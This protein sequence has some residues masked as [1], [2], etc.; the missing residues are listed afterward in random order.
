MQTKGTPDLSEG[1]WRLILKKGGKKI[2]P[3]E[4]SKDIIC[5]LRQPLKGPGSPGCLECYQIGSHRK[6]AL[7]CSPLQDV[8]LLGCLVFLGAT[9]SNALYKGPRHRS[10]AH[11]DPLPSV[12]Q[13]H[14]L[15]FSFSRA[16]VHK[17]YRL[18][19]SF[20]QQMMYKKAHFL[21]LHWDKCR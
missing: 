11:S 4:L 12:S 18:S 16:G 8:H 6:P 1:Q 5:F 21:P 13:S 7:L 20:H 14:Q 17:L 15:F 9:W 3:R 19:W 2:K 10:P